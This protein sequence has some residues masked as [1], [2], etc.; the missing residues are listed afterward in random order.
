MLFKGISKA[1]SLKNEDQYNT[2]GQFWDDM[3]DIYGLE[4]L[5]GLGYKWESCTI[6]YAI[7]LKN[8]EIEEADFEMELPDNGWEEVVGLTDNLK[9]IYDEIYKSGR[10]RLELE[11]FTED[12]RCRILY[13]R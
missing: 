3:S 12:G 8:G 7:G 13:L 2:I 1:F 4:N 10:L 6:Y 11:S 5:I 9:E